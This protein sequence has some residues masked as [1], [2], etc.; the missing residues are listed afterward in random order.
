MIV[1]ILLLTSCKGSS[2]FINGN[3]IRYIDKISSE[4]RYVFVSSLGNIEFFNA[5]RYSWKK[6][7]IEFG[8][9]T[10]YLSPPDFNIPA[11]IEIFNKTI[12][13][14]PAGIAVWAVDPLL[15]PLINRAT[16]AGI[17][18]VTVVGDLPNSQRISYIGSSQYE[19]GYSTGE[20]LVKYIGK[21]GKIAI[22]S[23]PGIEMFDE[24]ESGLRASL[25]EYPGIEIITVGD[26]KAD[27]F[28]AV[29]IAKE[30]IQE[31]PEL[32]G[33]VGLDST[34]AMGAALAVESLNKKGEIGIVG[35]DRN[36]DVLEKIKSGTITVSVAQ[37][38]VLMS[39]W[40]LQILINYNSYNYDLTSNNKE[41]DVTWIPDQII[42]P[43]NYVNISNVDLYLDSNKKYIDY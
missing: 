32:T 24:R 40:A 25:I 37:G 28:R 12:E 26:T 27:S 39:F 13:Q 5:H 9:K 14:K 22:L 3:N 2:E 6:A 31:H 15:E 18:V 11:M 8:V 10:E 35:M 4:D 43:S 30:L 41:A 21:S 29:K 36:T 23:L 17:P 42:T 16:A 1:F 7:G 19:L 20:A 33:F 38:D 34:S